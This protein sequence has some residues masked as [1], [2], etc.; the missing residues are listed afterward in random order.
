MDDTPNN[1]TPLFGSDSDLWDLWVFRRSWT[2]NPH[3]L[4]CYSYAINDGVSIEWANYLNLLGEN[5]CD[6]GFEM[7][8]Q[9]CISLRIREALWD[10]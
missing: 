5:T 10:D 8:E 4:S 3:R 6:P 1:E 9:G 2:R 7:D